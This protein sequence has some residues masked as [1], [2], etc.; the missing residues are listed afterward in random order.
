MAR[1]V[2][3]GY[4]SGGKRAGQVTRLHVVREEGP[5]G[6]PPGSQ[7]L[8]G[9]SARRHRNSD[10]VVIDPLPPRPPD[11]LS[12]CPKC[13]GHLAEN[14]G[15]LDEVAARLAAHDPSMETR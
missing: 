15:L 7:T 13:V 14:L 12:W 6:A 8:C 5:P 3:R 11:G 9:Q 1:A 10:P 2:H 4:W